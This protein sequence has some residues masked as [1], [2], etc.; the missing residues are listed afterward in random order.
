MTS[1]NKKTEICL[2]FTGIIEET[3]TV[4]EIIKSGTN[5]SF[6]VE[7]LLS[8]NLKIDQSL[9]H[10]GVCLTVEEIKGNCHKVTAIEETLL[11]TNMHGWKEGTV[12]NLERCLQING[13]LDGHFVQGHVDCTGKCVDNI[14]KEGSWEFKIEFSEKFA[15]FIIEKGSISLNGISLTVFDVSLNSFRVAII[16][17][18]FANTN[19]NTLE[20]GEKVNLEFDLIGKYIQ[21]RI[22]LN[23]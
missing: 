23:T 14:E 22:F 5:L 12:V 21:R 9:S 16:P 11:K 15:E 19:L 10:D 3:G 2:M 4:K 1:K 18:T 20:T 6:W 7:S 17:Y 13:R 8:A